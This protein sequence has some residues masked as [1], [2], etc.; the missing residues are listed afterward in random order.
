MTLDELEAAWN[1]QADPFN[2]WEELGIDEIVAFAQQQALIEA[3]EAFEGTRAFNWSCART[4][5]N[6]SSIG[7]ELRLMAHE[8]DI[9]TWEGATVTTLKLGK[10][11]YCDTKVRSD[12]ACYGKPAR[13]IVWRFWWSD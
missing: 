9:W 10:L 7:G 2:Q 1:A 3:A 12:L 6:G 13:H 4:Y 8:R 11:I 5:E